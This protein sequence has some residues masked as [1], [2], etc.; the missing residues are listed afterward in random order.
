MSSDTQL[1]G[2]WRLETPVFRGSRNV[3]STLL[4]SAERLNELN[5]LP[6]PLLALSLIEDCKWLFSSDAIEFYE[7]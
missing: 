6:L 3:L 1:G 5:A 7:N 2:C 4:I